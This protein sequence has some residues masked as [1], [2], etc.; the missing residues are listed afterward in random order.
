ME[1]FKKGG[2][3]WEREGAALKMGGL[4]DG[5]WAGGGFAPPPPP[6]NLQADYVD[7]CLSFSSLSNKNIDPSQLKLNNQIYN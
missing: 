7:F 5:E 1:I 6:N 4:E 3:G 2:K